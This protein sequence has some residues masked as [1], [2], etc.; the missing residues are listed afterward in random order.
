MHI[1]C[2]NL[3]F[4]GYQYLNG[5]DE[6]WLCLKCKSELFQFGNL[7]NKTF[8]QYVSSSKKQNKDNGEDNSSNLVPKPPP[9]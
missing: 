8:N 7:N 3:N 5:N 1:K 2:N 6:P 4:I 9:I